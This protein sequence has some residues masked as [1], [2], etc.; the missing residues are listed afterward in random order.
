MNAQIKF[1]FGHGLIVFERVMPLW[2]WKKRDFFSFRSLYSRQLYTFNSNLPHGCVIGMGRTSLK[3]VMVWWF[4]TL[5][6]KVEI[7]IFLSLSSQQLSLLIQLK[8]NIWMCHWNRNAQ[9]KFEFGHDS[10]S[11]DKV[12]PLELGKKGISGFCS[13]S[14]KQLYTFNSIFTYGYLN[15]MHRSS[16]NLVMVW[17]FLKSYRSWTLK[18]VKF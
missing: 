18:K 1:E 4:L 10:I 8:F 3:L 6:K 15:G 5:K 11:F 2:L 7:F 17:W 9:G 14:P 12:I 13:L 16:S